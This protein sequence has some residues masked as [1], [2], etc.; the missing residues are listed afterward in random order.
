MC[1]LSRRTH[2]LPVSKE[3]YYSVKRDLL[4]CQKRPTTC[5]GCRAER[6]LF[7]VK[8]ERERERARTRGRESGR[9]EQIWSITEQ[10][11]IVYYYIYIV[12]IIYSPLLWY[13][14]IGQIY[15]VYYSDIYSLL[16]CY[17]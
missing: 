14:G 9:A 17:I 13:S 16:L 7:Q 15:T 6:T 10:I 12:V 3:T 5:A 1:R 4:Q 11:F 2:T 8:A